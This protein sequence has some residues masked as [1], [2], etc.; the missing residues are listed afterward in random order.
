MRF[1]CYWIFQELASFLGFVFMF[2]LPYKKDVPWSSIKWY[3]SF[4]SVDKTA[5]VEPNSSPCEPFKNAQKL[6][7]QTFETAYEASSLCHVSCILVTPMSIET[8]YFKVKERLKYTRPS[9]QG[10][11]LFR[12]IY[13]ACATDSNLSVLFRCQRPEPCLRLQPSQ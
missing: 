12:I 10:S 4:V 2:F 8:W 13:V 9:F 6:R 7:E 11:F 5:T 3:H 1:A